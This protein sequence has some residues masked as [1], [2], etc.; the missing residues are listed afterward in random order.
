M[1]LLLPKRWICILMYCLNAIQSTGQNAKTFDITA[2]TTAFK[3]SSN[4][5]ELVKVAD[6]PVSTYN[7]TAQINF[8]LFELQSGSLSHS[9]NLNYIGGAGVPVEQDG[10]WVGLGWDLSVGGAITRTA[11]GRNDEAPAGYYSTAAAT[12]LPTWTNTS[13]GNWANTL[14][15]C[16]RRDIGNGRLDIAPDIYYINFGG[17]SAKMFF[18][19]SGTPFFSPFKAWKISGTQLTGFTIII[20]DGTRYEFKT[21]EYSSTSSES[22]PEDATSINA[23][24]SAWFLTRIVSANLRDSISFHYLPTSYTYEDGIPSYT[25]YDALPGQ[26]MAPCNTGAM[27]VHRESYTINYQSVNTFVVDSIM[28]NNGKI[29]FNLNQDR[30]DVN[31]GNK[32]RITGMNFYTRVATSYSPLKKILFGQLFTKS[33]SNQPLDK[34]MLLT[35]YSEISGK[36]TL[37]YSFSYIDP[38]DLPN[39]KS[40]SQDYWGYYNG[41]NNSTMIP[42]YS[43]K[44]GNTLSGANREPD[45]I[46]MQLGLLETVTYPTGGVATFNYEPHRYSYYNTVY[47]YEFQRFDSTLEDASITANTNFKPAPP[48]AAADTVELIMPIA[49]GQI[50]AITYFVKGK[51]LG[52][53]LAEVF[54]YDEDWNLKAG[55][56]DSHNQTLNLPP[57]L[58]QPGK[59]YY[60][61]ASRDIATEQARITVY[62]KKFKKTIVPT[63]FSKM[64]GGNRIK[65]ITMYDGI[66]HGNDIVKRYKYELNDSI[67][68][69]VLMDLPKYIDTTF[70]AFYCNVGTS[71]GAL[72]SYKNGDIAYTTRYSTSLN[73]LGRTQGAPVG[74]SK[75][76]ILY[77][78]NGENGR[79]DLFYTLTGLYDEGSNVYP[80]APKA[81]L[82]DLRG[83]MTARKV[84]SSAGNIIQAT[85]NTYNLN[86][87]TGSPNFKWVWAAKVGIRRSNGFPDSTCPNLAN[88]SFVTKMYKVYQFWPILQSKTDT[89]YDINGNSLNTKTTYLYDTINLQVSSETSINSDLSTLVK[90]YKYPRNYTDTAVYDSMV[91]RNM[92]S[93]KIETVITRSNVQIYQEFNHFGFFN[94]FIAPASMDFTNGNNPLEKRLQYLRYDADGNLQEQAKSDDIREVYLW[95][96]NNEYPVARI[97]G[98]TYSAVSPLVTASILNRPLSEQALRTEL[99]KIRTALSGSSAQVFTYTYI[100]QLGVSSET[101]AAGRT[102]YYQYDQLRRLITV[103]DLDG[104][105]I[106]QFEYKYQVP[107]TE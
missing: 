58:L 97:I 11:L 101:D 63:I 28:Y 8:T 3:A 25:T 46:Y 26:N 33:T 94:N 77:G 62:Y 99:Q 98:S 53:A 31:S 15:T 20:E 92:I 37:K 16:Y 72:T 66:D 21:I 60:L 102:T 35:S 1:A 64:A 52:D 48:A 50:W 70:T 100:P 49:A 107:V 7:G 68:S 54:I 79:E 23:G 65:R 86:N 91:A 17:Q 84:Y 18:D 45:S 6:I 9:I 40:F 4:A 51:I 88:W 2:P 74:Y 71:D 75:V 10:N 81:S 55:A 73:N 80:Y 29:V 96:Y 89:T 90:N 78:E 30:E 14:S 13:A 19:K 59:K 44:S 34:R 69:G 93:Q 95:G 61:I 106:R 67:S 43:D 87:T 105:I 42:V 27:D 12:G 104:N 36:D 47:Q 24:N 57:G 41:K 38:E 32:Y 22:Y 103:K 76:S 39:K 56:G 82:D 5:T 83:L 85:T